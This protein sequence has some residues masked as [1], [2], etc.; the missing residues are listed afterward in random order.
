MV[1]AA[2][3]VVL[4]ADSHVMELADFLDEFLEPEQ[5]ARLRRTQMAA[6]EGVLAD[7][8]RLAETRRQDPAAAAEAESRLLTDKG[9]QAM[10]GFDPVERS[11]VLDLLGFEGQLVFA[12]FASAMFVGR[13]LDRYYAGASA[14][15]RAM[16]KFCAADD[17]LLPVALVPLDDPDRAV[18]LTEEAIGAGCAAVMVPSTAAGERAPSHPDLDGFWGTLERAGVPF[19]LHVGGGGRLLDPAFHNNAMP[20]TDHLGGGEN[21]RAKD[22]LAIHH[23]PEVFLGTLVLDGLFDRFPGLR[24]GCIEQGA[25][26][27]VS[28]L[29]HLDHAQ[30]AFARTEEPLRRLA[31]PPSEYVRRHL[32]FTP[33]PGEPVGWMIEEAGP[34]LFMF[35]TDYPHPEGGRDPM[36]KFEATLD[37]VGAGDRARFYAGNMA[38]LLG[39]DAPGP[40]AGPASR[41]AP[42]MGGGPDR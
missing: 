4:D 3:R 40:A 37:G 30:R 5:A 7:A 26:W 31:A 11:R 32:K 9:W 6:L 38:E 18:S 25:G 17:R 10:G 2:G 36:A 22:Y 28:W 33:F 34:E 16:A 8:V 13:D 19:V 27:V 1:Y 29:R 14:Q 23:S 12:T 35:S 39:I 41:S 15:N 21:V 42:T 24:G 20:V